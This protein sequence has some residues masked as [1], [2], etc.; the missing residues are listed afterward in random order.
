MS[1]P[2]ER[3]MVVLTDVVKIYR[4]GTAPVVALDHV[5]LAIER[6]AMTAIVGP[7]GSGK[8]TLLNILGGLDTPDAGRVLVNGTD[9][10]SQDEPELVSFRRST[11][12]FVFQ[13]FDL[14]PI[15]TAWE[16]VQLPLL[17]NRRD[18]R[19]AGERARELLN[20]VGLADRADHR[21]GTLSGGEQQR[22]AIARA[23]ANDPPLLLADEPTGNLDSETGQ[24]IVTLLKELAHQEHK[25][26]VIVTHDGR[27]TEVADDVYAIKDG[28]VQHIN[29]RQG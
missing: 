5:D 25:A 23:L 29:Q 16:N 26:V 2:G 22:V 10:S 1:N 6:G 20:R 17:Y 9:L 18:R 12:G 27:L 3:A 8:T 21:P 28:Q 7:S 13:S 4:S 14:I 24:E 19:Y 11:V 15:L